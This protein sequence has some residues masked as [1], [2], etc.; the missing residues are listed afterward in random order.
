MGMPGKPFSENAVATALVT[1]LVVVS[2]ILVSH[3]ASARARGDR[4]PRLEITACRH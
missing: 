4:R 1:G 2:D 3:L